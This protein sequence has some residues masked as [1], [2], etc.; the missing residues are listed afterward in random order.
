[1]ELYTTTSYELAKQ[2]TQRYS[3]SFSLSSRLFDR[4]IRQHIYAIYG[5]VRIADEIVDTYVGEDRQVQLRDLQHEVAR[6]QE[7]GYSANPLVHAFAQTARIYGIADDII[8]PFF[9]S[10][11]TDVSQKT[12]TQ[13]EYETYIYGSAEVI[14]L[15]CLRV[16]VAGRDSQYEALKDGARA[17]GAAYQK[18]NFLRDM[19]ADFETRGRVYFPGIQFETLSEEQKQTIVADIER[20]FTAAQSS[21]HRLPVGA[22]RAVRA[23]YYYYSALLR[24]LQRTPAQELCDRRVRIANWRKLLLLLKAWARV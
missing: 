3:T 23:S 4:T 11:N 10:M 20:D 17:L 12:F 21:L 6:A 16:F 22:R 8:A 1:M 15:M 24:A 18:V 9:A 5:L 14:G 13:N 2:L 19:N 7:V